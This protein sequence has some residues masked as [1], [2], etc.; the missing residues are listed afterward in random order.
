MW[1]VFLCLCLHLGSTKTKENMYEEQSPVNRG[2]RSRKAQ[3]P[4]LPAAGAESGYAQYAAA[5]GSESQ[6]AW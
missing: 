1:C 3:L 4:V 5:A 6:Y 2:H